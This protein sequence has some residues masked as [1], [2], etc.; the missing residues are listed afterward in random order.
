M[1]EQKI[2]ASPAARRLAKELEINLE[3]VAAIVG[4]KRIQAEDVEQYYYEDGAAK[5][6]GETDENEFFS[7]SEARDETERAQDEHAAPAEDAA[8]SRVLKAGSDPEADD[9]TEEEPAE[10]T[11]KIAEN[12]P[13]AAVWEAP[14]IS[15]SEENDNQ[16]DAVIEDADETEPYAKEAAGQ[17]HSDDL[18]E[19]PVDAPEAFGRQEHDAEN[20]PENT[21]AVEPEAVHDFTVT[22]EPVAQPDALPINGESLGTLYAAHIEQAGTDATEDAP[23]MNPFSGCMAVSFSLSKKALEQLFFARHIGYDKG[24]CETSVTVC[25]KTLKSFGFSFFENKINVIMVS[26]DGRSIKKSVDIAQ[27]GEAGSL[28]YDDYD[29]LSVVHVWILNGCVLDSFAK[30]ETGTLDIFVADR[31]PR[32]KVDIS[33]G[34]ALMDM[35]ELICFAVEYKNNMKK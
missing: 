28:K 15:R 8:F 33:C 2:Q 23:Y 34:A 31:E 19:D 11:E 32:I 12:Q 22:E 27:F 4:D 3:D 16:K 21:A 14:E 5:D 24:L 10:E 35:S 26:R 1:S 29:P 20:E 13:A 7:L 9:E 17:T 25:G 18:T 30:I 6:D